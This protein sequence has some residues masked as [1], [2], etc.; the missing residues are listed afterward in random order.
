MAQSSQ[1]HRGLGQHQVQPRSSVHND[2][3]PAIANSRSTSRRCSTDSSVLTAVLP[4]DGGI[5]YDR[6]Y[7][8]RADAQRNVTSATSSRQQLKQLA[9]TIVAWRQTG[10]RGRPRPKQASRL[11]ELSSYLQDL[12]NSSS[13]NADNEPTR[14]EDEAAV[15]PVSAED[16]AGAQRDLALY[17]QLAKRVE[18][19]ELERVAVQTTANSRNNHKEIDAVAQKKDAATTCEVEPCPAKASGVDAACQTEAISAA[20]APTPAAAATEGAAGQ[21]VDAGHD[22]GHR[23]PEEHMSSYGSASGGAHGHDNDLGG[24]V[25]AVALKMLARRFK[26]V[27][28]QFD[29]EDDVD[30]YMQGHGTAHGHGTAATGLGNAAAA[31]SA[32][33]G[34]QSKNSGMVDAGGGGG[35]TAAAADCELAG[36]GDAGATTV[37]FGPKPPVTVM[38]VD[39]PLRGKPA[40]T[41]IITT[42]AILDGLSNTARSSVSCATT[43]AKGSRAMKHRELDA[44]DVG[45]PSTSHIGGTATTTARERAGDTEGLERTQAE[46]QTVI[47]ASSA[48]P[49]AINA[50]SSTPPHGYLQTTSAPGRPAQK[51]PRNELPIP[52]PCASPK[53]PRS[54]NQMMLLRKLKDVFSDPESEHGEGLQS[55]STFVPLG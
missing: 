52:I 1:S 55:P 40:I 17:L 43:A 23:D 5:Y 34:T 4:P 51:S 3:A 42:D 20:A 13:G 32:A 12:L 29:V 49:T 15:T 22:D 50:V 19:L 24:V 8:A 6:P 37:T 53:L 10:D 35:I 44:T 18:Q 48:H 31:A 26:A 54:R 45:G 33:D 25:K 27:P 46:R 9:P 47:V 2:R 30:Q 14:G 11:Q 38:A 39:L 41:P 16:V 36:T 21:P 28:R 7:P